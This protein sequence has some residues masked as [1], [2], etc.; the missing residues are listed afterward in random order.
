[1][2]FPF[3]VA[4]LFDSWRKKK[5]TMLPVAAAAAVLL[6]VVVVLGGVMD[7]VDSAPVQEE[8][9]LVDPAEVVNL[10]GKVK[11]NMEF[12]EQHPSECSF[13]KDQRGFVIGVSLHTWRE[14]EV[15]TDTHT[16]THR[17]MHRHR[18]THTGNVWMNSCRLAFKRL[19]HLPWLG[20]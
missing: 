10:G 20:S 18:H 5:E 9:G 4:R 12:C 16:H 6:G 11:K 14:R 3:W 19:A 2:H 8:V 13:P 17:D 1:M 7:G 15:H